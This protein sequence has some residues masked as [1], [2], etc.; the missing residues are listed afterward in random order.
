[1][2]L[3]AILFLMATS[4]QVANAQGQASWLGEGTVS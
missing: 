4:I 1:M 3:T 2:Y